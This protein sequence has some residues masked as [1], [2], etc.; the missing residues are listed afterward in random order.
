MADIEPD[1]LLSKNRPLRPYFTATPI[2]F[3]CAAQE[4]ERPAGQEDLA[5]SG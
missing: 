3:L 1:V 2:P 4:I 5:L